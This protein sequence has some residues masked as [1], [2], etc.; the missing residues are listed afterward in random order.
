M[1]LLIALFLVI[2]LLVFY[3]RYLHGPWT[4]EFWAKFEKDAK[5]ELYVDG[6]KVEGHHH[7]ALV[8]RN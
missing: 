6:K 3:F 4:I 8:K 2:T 1:K 5:Y 7:Y